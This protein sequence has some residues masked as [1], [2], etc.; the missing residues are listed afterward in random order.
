MRAPDEWNALFMGIR[1]GYK[2]DTPDVYESGEQMVQQAEAMG[3]SFHGLRVLD[4][5]CGNGRWAA[6]LT[7]RGVSSYLGLDVVEGSI[8]FC[9]ET[10]KSYP[11]FQFD[12]LPAFNGRYGGTKESRAEDV[13]FPVSTYCDIIIASSLF[14]HFERL[15]AVERYLSEMRRVAAQACT[16]YV[17]WF[18]SPP[19]EVTSDARRTVFPETDIRAV[20]EK[21]GWKIHSENGGTKA[22]WG[23][24]WLM[25]CTT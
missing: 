17:T 13:V 9:R 2:P 16:L 23:D 19:N 21:T 1:H 8:A 18:R 11:A 14:T 24:Q 5:G 12:A 22:E 3:I 25:L 20:L 6:V 4:V 7:P 10:F 15:T